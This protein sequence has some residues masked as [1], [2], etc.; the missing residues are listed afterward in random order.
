M[1]SDPISVIKVGAVLLVTMPAD[2]DDAT[3]SA[4]QERTLHAM[5]Q[6]SAA[7]LSLT[8]PKWKFSTLTLPGLSR[9]PPKWLV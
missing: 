3:V 5:E 6:H 2:P 4:L 1:N 7:A 8:F 9:R